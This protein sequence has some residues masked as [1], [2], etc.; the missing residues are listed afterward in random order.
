MKLILIT[1][2]HYFVQEDKILTALF[3]E[4]LETLHL[5]KPYT[6][7]IL[8]E[9][10]L[11]LIPQQFHKRIVIHENFHLQKGRF[12]KGVHL[13]R[14]FPDLPQ[15]YTGHISTSC[16]S[17]EEVELHKPHCNYLF[18]SPI[19]D[20]ISKE[21]YL[22]SYTPEEIRHAN[23]TG[24]IDQKIIALGGVEENNLDEIKDYGFGGAAI[25]GALWN[26]FDLRNDQDYDS[27]IEYFKLLKRVA[28]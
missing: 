14:R 22:S 4:G 27:I 25:L 21:G 11:A 24:L 2:P 3:E 13:N 6:S 1:T 23:R 26:K 18:L 19:F 28:D 8:A 12:L 16:H 17:F 10:L 7:P 9:R 20:S 5:R 15:D